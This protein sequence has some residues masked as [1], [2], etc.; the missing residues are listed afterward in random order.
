MNEKKNN[1]LLIIDPSPETVPYLAKVLTGYELI[2]AQSGLEGLELVRSSYPDIVLLDVELPRMNGF[3]VVRRIKADPKTTEIPVIFLTANDKTEDKVKGLELGASDYITK[4]FDPTEVRARVR[5]QHQIHDLNRSLRQANDQLE[6][7]LKSIS[8]RTELISRDVEAA[9][10][11]QR[12]L[13]PTTGLPV[14]SVKF[15]WRFIPSAGVAG[16]LLDFYVLDQD[17]IGFYVVDVSGHGVASGLLASSIHQAMIPVLDRTSL[18]RS[19]L[20]DGTF[21]V[22]PPEEVAAELERTFPYERFD[23]YFTMFYGVLDHRIGKMTYFNAGHPPPVLLGNEGTVVELVPTGP[24][25]GLGAGVVEQAE[26]GFGPQDRI[27]LYS[28]GLSEALNREEVQ[29]GRKRVVENL[30]TANQSDLK[31]MIDRLL[32]YLWEYTDQTEPDDD[33]T[34][35]AVETTR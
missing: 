35:L 34:C 9:A 3:D 15:E 25:I 13:L 19:R 2:W 30:A 24:P 16:D 23:K 17:R 12:A 18:V 8:R 29:F 11:V 32:G 31:E 21:R 14:K 27:V 4:P 7:A 26:I 20:D 22:A 5:T 10:S 6:A 33:I 1:K 28:D